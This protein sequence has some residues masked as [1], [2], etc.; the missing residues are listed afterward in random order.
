MIYDKQLHRLHIIIKIKIKHFP[1]AN[2]T[3]SVRLLRLLTVLRYNP[4]CCWS[5]H[6]TG[7]ISKLSGT[8]IPVI[9]WFY[10]QN[11]GLYHHCCCFQ[12]CLLSMR[13]LLVS[14]FILKHIPD[15]QLHEN[16]NIKSHVL[17]SMYY[18]VHS[19]KVLVL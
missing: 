1:G 16:I 2:K 3:K 9:A 12:P 13:Y 6:K 19:S 7:Y 11:L 14:G 8:I 15:E 4:L 5:S 17:H 10:L 18:V